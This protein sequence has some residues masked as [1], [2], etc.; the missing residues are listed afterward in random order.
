MVNRKLK[1]GGE[2][3]WLC[4]Q[5]VGE[6]PSF[7]K[8]LVEEQVREGRLLQRSRNTKNDARE[9]LLEV[10]KMK[11]D[12]TKELELEEEE[13][14][15]LSQELLNDFQELNEEQVA[16]TVEEASKTQNQR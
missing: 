15:G 11:D 3:R 5:G 2:L 13:D 9:G 6:S 4:E 10:L 16:R 12:L 8:F 14:L 7:R 1:E